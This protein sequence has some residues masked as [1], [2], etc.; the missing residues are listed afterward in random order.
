MNAKTTLQLSLLG[1]LALGTAYGVDAEGIDRFRQLEEILPTANSYRSASGA[2]GHEYWQQQV[3]YQIDVKLDEEQRT[4]VGSET[5]TY[6]NN[7]PDSLS[8]LWLQLDQNRFHPDSHSVLTSFGPNPDGNPSYKDLQRMFDKQEFDGG[9]KIGSVTDGEG[10]VLKHTINDTMMRVDLAETLVS[11]SSTVFTVSWGHQINDHDVL[12]GRGGYEHFEKDGNDIFEIAQWFPRLCAYTDVNGWQHKQF[13][14][15]GEFTLEFGDYDVNITVPADHIVASTGV[16]Q[17]PDEVLSS[18]QRARYEESRSA[19]KPMFVVTPEEAEANEKER[20]DGTRTW[21]YHAENV[22]DF[23]WASS[24]KFIWD[25][26]GQMVG[27]RE[28]MAMSYYPKEGEPLWSRYSTHSILHTLEVYSK[29]TFD[30]PYPVAISVNGPVGGMEYP[31]ICFNGPRPEEDGTYSSRTKY[32]LISVIIHEVGHNWF[33]M[34]VNSDERQWTWMDE[35]LNTFL[36]YLAEQEWEEDYPSWRGKPDKIVSYM[37]SDYQVPIMTNSESLKQFG[38]NAYAKPATALNILRESVMGREL[39]DFAFKEYSNRWRFK[40]PEPSDLFRSMEDASAVDLDWFW[41]GWFYTTESVDVAIEGVTRYTIDTQN[42]DIEK[43]LARAKQDAEPTNLSDMRN[44]GMR[45]RMDEF[46]EL[47]DFYNTFDKNDVTLKDRTDFEKMVEGLKPEQKEAL[48]S[49]FNFYSIQLSN[50]GGLLSPI[51]L[52]FEYADG[53]KQVMRFPAEIWIK[54]TESLSKLVAT[55]QEVVRVT[56]DPHLETADGDLS[57][58]VFPPE[59]HEKRMKLRQQSDSRGKNP[60][61]REAEAA[62]RLLEAEAKAKQEA[63]A[64]ERLVEEEAK[65]KEDAGRAD[66]SGTS[67]D[68]SGEGQ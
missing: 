54:N 18:E 29:Y 2:P 49:E 66:A 5:I 10:R 50:V 9:A 61:Q 38:N 11:G 35:G 28:V 65:A 15:S 58:N 25:S 62:K 51:I 22:R 48:A 6:T 39:F 20:A 47:A 32:G 4:L 17:N 46:P 1:I 13:L 53:S 19:A 23:A 14:G 44:K 59:I 52:E 34:I 55:K 30:Y 27:D 45:R 40:R 7:S 67:S 3:D 60:M 26:K 16:L 57:N 24:R 42:P 36:Q 41:R 31:M 56:L 21:S 43:P 37:T 33:P 68:S 12:G 64:A 8:Y 63:E